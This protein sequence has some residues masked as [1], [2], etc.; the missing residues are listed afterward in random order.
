LY[1]RLNDPMHKPFSI[2]IALFLWATPTLALD[3]SGAAII[4]D[5]DSLI[6][7]GQK[8]RLNG[9][10]AFE[11][12]QDCTRSGRSYNCGADAENALRSM[13]RSGASCTGTEYDGYDR[14]LATCR[15]ASGEDVQAAMVRAGHA[16]AYRKYSSAYISEE[17]DAK[18]ARRGAWAGA[19]MPPWEF[20]KLK[21]ETADVA[22]P[23]PNCPIKGNI[24]SKGVKIYHV[25]WSRSYDRTRINT[26]KGE[27]WFCD[28]AEALTAGW[29][30]PR[31]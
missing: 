10:D 18:A 13:L 29:R 23:D 17:E 6:I 28:E 4:T 22:A 12:G 8:I 24:N 7:A 26:A 27:R 5:G 19:F 15:S 20:R 9:I 1:R 14:L 3:L 25:P 30:A 16:L 21:W 2:A 11:N 31:R